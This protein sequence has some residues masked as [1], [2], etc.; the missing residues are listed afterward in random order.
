MFSF[1]PLCKRRD[2]KPHPP[3]AWWYHEKVI[4]AGM[5][6]AGRGTGHEQVGR[7]LPVLMGGTGRY[8][9]KH[10]FSTIFNA[11]VCEHK[12]ITGMP[13]KP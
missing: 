4:S 7:V 12:N 9:G 1:A 8:L 2:R 11:S 10:L 6:R 13:L 3:A 5:G